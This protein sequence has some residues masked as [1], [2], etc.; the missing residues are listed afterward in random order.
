[1]LRNPLAKHEPARAALLRQLAAR[2]PD[3]APLP[4]RPAA[5]RW[6]AAAAHDMQYARCREANAKNVREALEMLAFSVS[7]WYNEARMFHL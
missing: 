7:L 5:R 3:A 1:M 6:T 4:S 2:P